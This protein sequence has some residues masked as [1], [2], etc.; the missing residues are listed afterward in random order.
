MYDGHAVSISVSLSKLHGTKPYYI[1]MQPCF[2]CATSMLSIFEGR[3]VD[4]ENKLVSFS[5]PS[6]PV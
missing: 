2:A 1:A 5:L 4:D 6:G 3:D